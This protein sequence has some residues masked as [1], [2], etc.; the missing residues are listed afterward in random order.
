MQQLERSSGAPQLSFTNLTHTTVCTD[1]ASQRIIL[2]FLSLYYRVHTWTCSLI[3]DFGGQKKH[4][5]S[6][7]FG[8][9]DN[10]Q[11][12]PACRQEQRVPSECSSS[13]SSSVNTPSQRKT[14]KKPTRSFFAA[15]NGSFFSQTKQ[16][17]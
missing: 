5:F 9:R 14:A 16:A 2:S 3:L 13:S 4:L 15:L 10:F 6:F 1:A 12:S 17:M 11:N 7:F 8:Y